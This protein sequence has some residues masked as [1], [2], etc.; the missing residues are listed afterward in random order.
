MVIIIPNSCWSMA[1]IEWNKIW[2]Y[3]NIKQLY[4]PLSLSLSLSLSLILDLSSTCINLLQ[5][6]SSIYT[7]RLWRFRTNREKN[8][9]SPSPFSIHL[10]FV[11]KW[12]RWLSQTLT[13]LGQALTN[14]PQDFWTLWTVLLMSMMCRNWLYLTLKLVDHEMLKQ[15][16]LL[17]VLQKVKLVHCYFHYLFHISR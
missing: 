2:C 1:V 7:G 15:I 17:T 6:S 5:S 9:Q 12:V 14:I 13:G 3:L 16:H 11:R 8:H 10:R 4:P